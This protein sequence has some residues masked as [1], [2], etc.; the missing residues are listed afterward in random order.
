MKPVFF[1]SDIF[2]GSGYGAG[3]PLHI[4]RVWPVIDICRDMGWLA[5]GQY[6]SVPVAR[7]DEL[8]L[9]HHPSYVAALQEA[10][11][12]QVLDIA[13]QT[14]HQ[15]GIKGNP[16]YPEMYRRPATAAKASL[17]AAEMMLA[18]QARRLFN[19]S[20]G[21]HHGMPD[22]ANGFCFVNDP[23]LAIARLLQGGAQK[24]A[25]L[26]IDAHHPDGIEAH[27]GTDARV[28]LYSVHEENRWPRTGTSGRK[29]RIWNQT[30]PRGSGDQPFLSAVMDGFLPDLVA[31]K[32]DYVI[33]QAGADALRDDP[34]SGLA[35]S[36]SAYLCVIEACLDLPCPVLITGGGGYNP[37][38]TARAWAAIWGLM[39]GIRRDEM[40]KLILPETTQE[41]MKS[42]V[43][44]HR[45]GRDKPLYWLAR[46]IDPVCSEVDS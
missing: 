6:I 18:G 26:D 27:F 45:L 23:A 17:M 32:P 16:F 3:H 22:Y 8:A 42:L 46:I 4:P 29:D 5:D 34:Q 15:I 10:E 41:M 30:L 9:F 13:R 39:I 35:V 12:F 33:V 38:T 2:R 40:A 43:F 19:P 1:G 11:Q 7:P 37:F 20:G 44:E 31:S 24:I 21:T 25:Y 36:Q 14:R 28:S